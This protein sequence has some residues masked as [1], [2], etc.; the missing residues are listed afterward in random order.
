MRNLLVVLAIG[1]MAALLSSPPAI[2]QDT[3]GWSDLLGQNLKDWT[4][5]GDG[6][7]PWRLSS[8][9]ILSCGK[10]TDAYAPDNEVADGTLKFEYR[11]KP[12]GEKTGY[13]AAV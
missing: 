7:N 6:K 2:S 5:L 13:K 9:R 11:F 10:A 12:T 3:D 1:L 4:R 8:D